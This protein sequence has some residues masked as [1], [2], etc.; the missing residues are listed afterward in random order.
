[1]SV[2]INGITFVAVLAGDAQVDWTYDASTGLMKASI[3]YSNI[4]QAGHQGQ[5]AFSLEAYLTANPPAAGDT[6]TL[7]YD[8]NNGGNYQARFVSF[9]FNFDD[10]GNAAITVNGDAN[11]PDTIYGTSGNDTLNGNGG[12]DTIIGRGGNDTI[13]G[14]AGDDNIQ[15]N[16]GN[17]TITGGAGN[18]VING[19]AGTDSVTDPEGGDTITNVPPVVLDLN[20]DGVHFLGTEAGVRYD[21]GNGLVATA[22][23]APDDG[24]LVRDANGN[25][26]VDGASEFVFGSGDVTDLQA[27]A[28]YDTNHDGVL[29]AADADFGSFAVWQDANSNGVVDAGEMMSL[30]ARGITSISLSSDGI[31]YVAAGGQVDVSGTGSF[32]WANGSTGA[33][34]DA[35]FGTSVR[36]DQAKTAQANEGNTAILAAALAAAGLAAD[37]ASASTKH[38][39]SN[40]STHSSGDAGVH[41][42]ALAPV[43]LD[44]SN[45]GPGNSFVD[46]GSVT[47]QVAQVAKSSP[48]PSDDGK[49]HAAD[50]SAAAQSAA[51]TELLK[52]TDAP[53][54]NEV[55]DHTAVTAAAVSMPA[56]TVAAAAAHSGP[57]QG[58]EVVA[59]VLA[60]ALH[61][62]G[63]GTIDALVNSL[64]NHG[65]A[66]ATEAL[67]SLAAGG[68]S[69][70]DTGVLGG[71]SGAHLALTM[72]AMVVHQD[73]VPAHA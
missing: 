8:D 67:A 71:F 52:G 73:A 29:S 13:N 44:S 21:Y 10:P 53:V 46:L 24:I 55:T 69:N 39:D 4:Y 64:P 66:Q 72:E 63:G 51:P 37:A 32:T 70:G 16:D 31:G 23:A 61:G 45:G 14:G 33:L 38:V 18:D 57:V 40:G 48:N 11:L 7:H 1:V 30:T 60:D 42:L 9:N 3:D 58:N 49:S 65:G 22:W 5:A 54:H 56:P 28:A 34:A 2:I 27:L 19:G 25:G 12:N 62:G 15:G 26:T 35:A 41:N 17:D 43:A 36:A 59:Q 47:S 50:N 6:W 20:G 68:V